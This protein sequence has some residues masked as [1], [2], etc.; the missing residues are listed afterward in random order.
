MDE[1]LKSGA[2]ITPETSPSDGS[3]NIDVTISPDT[4]P[5]ATNTPPTADPEPTDNFGT[6]ENDVTPPAPAPLPSLADDPF[7]ADIPAPPSQK[8]PKTKRAGGMS[9]PL[10]ILIVVIL[11]LAAAAGVYF[12]Q[13]SQ[14]NSAQGKSDGLNQQISNL[15]KQINDLKKANQ[16]AAQKPAT[17]DQNVI[18]VTELGIQFTVPDSI[19]D[20][21]YTVKTNTFGTNQTELTA[22]FTTASLLA[23][24]KQCSSDDGAVGAISKVTGTYPTKPTPDN[25]DGP[26]TKQF[27]TFYVSYSRGQAACSMDKTVQA[28]QA[29]Q[30][31]AL[32]EA[33]K[34]VEP[35]N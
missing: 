19:K 16:Q 17:S 7:K 2:V 24:D 28:L 31:S 34:N 1:E 8:P 30:A 32:Q 22:Y 27:S 26:L 13:H 5:T 12:W 23:K 20:L 15:Q 10:L 14:V 33:V 4:A 35:L 9:K 25:T 6:S 11:M 21:T 29:S 18:K 3:Q